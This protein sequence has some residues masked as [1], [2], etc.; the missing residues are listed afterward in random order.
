LL[1]VY[2]ITEHLEKSH[3]LTLSQYCKKFNC[4]AFCKQ[5]ISINNNNDFIQKFL[6][7]NA[8][9][10]EEIGNL[11][12][13]SCPSCAESFS[14]FP[15]FQ[16]HLKICFILGNANFWLGKIVLTGAITKLIAH[17]CKFCTALVLCDQYWLREHLKRRHKKS[18]FDYSTETNAKLT[19]L[20]NPSKLEIPESAPLSKS[21]ENLCLYACKTSN[22]T[23]QYWTSLQHH[24]KRDSLV[25]GN[26][27]ST[28]EALIKIVRH[29]CAICSKMILCDR[30]RIATHVRQHKM[31]LGDYISKIKQ[32]TR[33]GKQEMKQ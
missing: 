4:L 20:P 15:K 32:D 17:E 31:I 25:C 21:V 28:K 26:K 23:F 8:F 5:K 11:C 29:E 27:T 14:D 22:R 12:M 9:I 24:L 7:H 1:D 10:T 2:L 19:Y 18:I 16:K 33:L 13:Y 3:R 6:R 30:S